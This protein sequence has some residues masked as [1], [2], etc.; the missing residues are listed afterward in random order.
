MARC[1]CRAELPPDAL[2]CHRCGKPQREDL[3]APEPPPAA[4]EEELRAALPL[5]EPQPQGLNNGLLL[6]TAMIGGAVVFLCSALF[7]M[8]TP[9]LA[10][11]GIVF[12]GFVAVMLYRNQSPQPV[13]VLNGLRLGWFTGFF[14]FLLAG[15]LFAVTALALS[16]PGA[17]DALIEGMRKAGLT[18]QAARDTLE[19]MRDPG[20][21]LLSLVASFLQ[22]TLL[23]SIGGAIAAKVFGQRPS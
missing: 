16:D 12:G 6:R 13:S 15:F 22:F 14:S 18:E 23:A 11:M 9:A 1:S 3:I 17:R 8:I 21:L 2:F 7:V 4:R 19:G 10:I 20:K 5:P